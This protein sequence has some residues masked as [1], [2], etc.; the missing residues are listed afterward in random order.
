MI[1]MIKV[2]SLFVLKRKGFED[3]GRRKKENEKP[4]KKERHQQPTFCFFVFNIGFTDSSRRNMPKL[5]AVL[6]KF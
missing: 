2:N 5:H 1:L 6:H 4:S 3:D